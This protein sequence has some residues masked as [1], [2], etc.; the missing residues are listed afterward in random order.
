MKPFRYALT[1]IV[2]TAAGCS[3]AEPPAPPSPVVVA[4]PGTAE[5]AATAE[6]AADCGDVAETVR[7]HLSADRVDT[8][9]VIGQCT[10]VEVATRLSDEDSEAGVELCDAAAEVAYTGDINSVRVLSATGA[11][12][13][14]GIP[15]APC[16]P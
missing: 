15:G 5:T 11:E 13:A 7:A 10:T 8:V 16:L 1:V 9:T 2:L 14:N 3:A 6:A 4:E 12:L